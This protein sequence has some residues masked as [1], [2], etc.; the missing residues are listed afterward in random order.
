MR[1]TKAL[2]FLIAPLVMVFALSGVTLNASAGPLIGGTGAI[3]EALKELKILLSQSA[4]LSRELAILNNAFR[5][6]ENGL[7]DLIEEARNLLAACDGEFD[8]EDPQTI[9]EIKLLLE[10][11]QRDKAMLLV[12][13][14]GAF[15]DFLHE[16]E[17]GLGELEG[18]I[19]GLKEIGVI[20][21][22]DAIYMEIKMN[23]CNQIVTLIDSEVAEVS[24]YLEDGDDGE[25]PEDPDP[26][27]SGADD[28]NDFIAIALKGLSME[29]GLDRV[30]WA[31]A[32]AEA[33]LDQAI[34]A[35]E[36]IEFK[37]VPA[38][39]SA[40][41]AVESK[42]KKLSRKSRFGA[43]R[44]SELSTVVAQIYTLGGQLVSAGPASTLDRQSLANGVYVVTY[45]D[46][47]V[48]KRVVLH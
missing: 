2:T 19:G 44:L 38:C 9:H 35:K 14:I 8:C 26:T 13:N 5:N 36:D 22:S 18:K 31:L 25:D 3:S 33:V 37:K 20:P 4:T 32:N 27:T 42:L 46:G 16:F 1:V 17:V 23:S 29:E 30:D 11:A 28:V 6:L 21:V 7:G 47:R 15:F 34:A 48:E 45:S 43:P 12:V 24:A 40:L 41:K 39:R 10:Q